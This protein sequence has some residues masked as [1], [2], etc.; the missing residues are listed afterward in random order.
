MLSRPA[1]FTG[2]VLG[3]LWLRSP[4]LRAVF[5]FQSR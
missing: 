3:G 4:S 2:P 1:K 5:P